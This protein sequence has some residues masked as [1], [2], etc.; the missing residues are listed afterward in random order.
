MI[1]KQIYT[2]YTEKYIIFVVSMSE[3]EFQTKQ[4]QQNL[5]I[6]VLIKKSIYF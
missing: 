4:I 5:Y 2:P 6:T 1:P 3:G